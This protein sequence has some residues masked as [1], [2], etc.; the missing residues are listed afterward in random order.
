MTFTTR[1]KE[2]L[3]LFLGSREVDEQTPFSSLAYLGDAILDLYVRFY[4]L[5]TCPGEGVE[6]LQ[7]R[8]IQFSN[9]HREKVFLDRMYPELQPRERQVVDKARNRFHRIPS[10]IHLMDYPKALAL[11]SLLGYLFLEKE[12]SRL[13]EIMERLIQEVKPLEKGL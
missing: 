6:K 7:K 13:M 4:L 2:L 11:E 8:G 1:F 12:Y 5:E 10:H 9:P 3:Q